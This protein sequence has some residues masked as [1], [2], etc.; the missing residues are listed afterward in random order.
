MIKI[1]SNLIPNVSQ[2]SKD[3]ESELFDVSEQKSGIKK[4]MKLPRRGHF[5]SF[6]TLLRNAISVISTNRFRRS[7]ALY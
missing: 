3:V 6:E 7:V 4:L 1:S 5:R 2:T